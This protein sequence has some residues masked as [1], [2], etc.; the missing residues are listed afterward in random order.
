MPRHWTRA[1]FSVSRRT[2]RLIAIPALC[3]MWI[4]AFY[5]FIHVFQ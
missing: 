5:L 4:S 1:P 3:G 2:Y